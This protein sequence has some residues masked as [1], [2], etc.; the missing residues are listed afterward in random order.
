MIWTNG[1]DEIKLPEGSYPL[2]LGW[3]IKPR[4]KDKNQKVVKMNEKDKLKTR[5]YFNILKVLKKAKYQQQFFRNYPLSE[6][7]L[8]TLIDIYHEMM[9]IL[10]IN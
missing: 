7:D 4:G 9:K 1:K 3:Y 8:F 10:F 2:E 5:I 6:T